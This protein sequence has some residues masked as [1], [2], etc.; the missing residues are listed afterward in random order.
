MIRCLA[1]DDEP[2]ALEQLKKYIGKVPFLELGEACMSA[3][4]AS[5]VLAE[6]PID[7][8]FVDINMPDLNGMDFVKSLLNPPL[9]VFTTAYSEYAIEGYKVNAVDYLLKPFGLDDFQRAANKV[10]RQYQLLHQS[11]PAPAPA[12][13]VATPT[14][15]ESN[16]LFVK[17]EYRMVR[18]DIRQI[19]YVEAMS[20]YLRL[21]LE[22]EAKPVIAL[23]SMKKLEERLPQNFMRVHRSYI[24]NLQKIQQVERGRIV[25]DKDTYIPVSDGYKDAFN[26]FLNERSVEK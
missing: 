23:L 1:I 19:R 8:I 22:G 21:Y 10:L 16:V 14:E 11:Q 17:S 6:Q 12:Q 15:E 4:A 3:L 9:V 18:I 7:A 24:V 26:K 2:L 13:M 25:M 20:E 5:K